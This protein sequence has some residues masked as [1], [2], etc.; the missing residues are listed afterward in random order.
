MRICLWHGWLLEGTGSNVYTARVAEVFRAQ[1]HDVALLC[2]ERHA[3]RLRF[4]DARGTVGAGGMSDLVEM[5]PG[6]AAGPGRL[7]LLRPQIGQL[8]PVFVWDEYEGFRVKTFLDLTDDELETYLARNVEALEVAVGQQ[9]SDVVIAGHA[10][11]GAAIARRAVGEGNYVAKIHGSDIEYAVRLQRRYAELAREG[12]EGARGVVGSSHDVIQRMLE[13]V[14]AIR[15]RVRVASPGVDAERFAPRQRREA[16]AEVAAAVAADPD[17]TRGRL[18]PLDVEVAAAVAARDAAALDALAL[19]YDQMAPDPTAANLLAQLANYDGPLV[20]YL[21]KLTPEKGVERMIEAVAL[22]PDTR[23]LVIG[24]GTYR[25]WFQALAL[26]LRRQ[27]LD[28]YRWLRERSEMRLELT[29]KEVSSEGVQLDFTGRLDHRYAP[30]VLAA[31]DVLVVPS[32]LAEAFG[33]VAAEAAAAG[34]FP[35]VARHSGL[36]EIAAALESEVGRPGLLSFE[37]GDEAT[38]R[39]V[40]KL[41][42][43]LSLPQGERATLSTALRGFVV[44]EWSWEATARQLLAAAGTA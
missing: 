18:A 23:G 35:L 21:G 42:G 3:E 14:P 32:T 22:L 38:G 7:T 27:D 16:L 11:P 15:D 17:V 30:G 25:E 24:F 2:Q 6:T 28:A 12:L 5:G 4:V 10:I 37:P 39:A 1:G 41:S 8:L 33:M 31:L 29:D 20:G 19:R 34:V 44:R 36:A 43:L 26:A 13:I 40:E 9:G